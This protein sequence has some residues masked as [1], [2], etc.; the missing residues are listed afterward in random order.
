METIRII[1]KYFFK[2]AVAFFFAALVWAFVA[3]LFPAA[4]FTSLK[5]S[6]LGSD[7]ES[8][9]WLPAP[10][11]YSGVLKSPSS[12]QYGTLYVAGEPYQ[13]WGNVPPTTNPSANFITPTVSSNSNSQINVNQQVVRNPNP[14]SP[15]NP[16]PTTNQYVRNMS[17]YP[18]SSIRT[19][20]I[21][22]GEA[23]GDLFNEGKFPI[24]TV[25]ARGAVVGV[26]SAIATTQWAVPGWVR[27]EARISHPLPEKSPCTMIFEEA[28]RPEERS[29]QPIR[30]P[31]PIS[32]N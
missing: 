25:N 5:N 1:I 29:R 4:S 8:R 22:V 11:N 20:L 23:R 2:I 21:F 18:G 31:L 28:L 16:S 30:V 9:D 19:G 24:I 12:G 17:I 26:S 3:L 15:N 10:R 14:Q 7:G 32:C 27:F 13:G 6:F